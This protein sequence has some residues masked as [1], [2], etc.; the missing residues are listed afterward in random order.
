MNHL[1]KVKTLV[2]L[3]AFILP[4]TL[5]AQD[6]LIKSSEIPAAIQN[7]V[8]THFPVQTITKA[9]IDRDGTKNEY[10][11]Q[12]NQYTE[13]EFDHNYKIKKIEGKSALPKSVVPASIND[14]IVAHYPKNAIIGWEAERKDQEVK[15]DN[16]VELKFNK[17]GEFIRVDN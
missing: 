10:E 16:G 3:A 14:Y 7:Y 17:N 2:A 4:F 13:L 11:I 12:L 8:K 5:T 9:E 1:K 6:S 15:L